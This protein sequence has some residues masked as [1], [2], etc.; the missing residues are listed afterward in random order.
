ML[1]LID[2]FTLGA[3]RQY[4]VLFGR[5][6]VLEETLAMVQVWSSGFADKFSSSNIEKFRPIEVKLL[7]NLRISSYPSSPFL[8]NVHLQ[9][10][11]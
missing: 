3:I 10:L 7:M 5:N 2:L 1:A 8:I 6:F 4:C 9:L 11:S